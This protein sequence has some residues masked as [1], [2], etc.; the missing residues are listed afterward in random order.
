MID[1]HCHFDAAHFD[2]DRARHLHQ[3]QLAGVSKIIMPA[4][5]S[6]QW[7]TLEALSAQFAP[8]Y[9]AL[10]VHP[11][12]VE[13]ESDFLSV[14]KLQALLSHSKCVAIGECGLD[15]AQAD[16]H[17]AQSKFLRAQCQLAYEL[18]LPIILHCRNA[19]QPLLEILRQFPKLRGVLHAFS[20]SKELGLAYIKRGFLLGVGGTITYPR[21]SKTRKAIKELPLQSLLLETDAPYM[22]LFG[23]QGAA[24]SPAFLPEIASALAQLKNI[25]A[26]Q[27]IAAT[28]DNAQRLFTKMA[29]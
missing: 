13:N 2:D 9:F 10:G 4:T 20:G 22:P 21:G 29:P 27:V 5:N 6:A 15:F 8:L 17:E 23:R 28:S 3:A 24:N 12:F 11:L 1:S 26:S 14:E 7:T 16:N 19:H 18:D 25:T